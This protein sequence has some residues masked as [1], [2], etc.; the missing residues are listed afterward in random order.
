[1]LDIREIRKNPD[2]TIS[3]LTRRYPNAKEEI[4]DILAL[5]AKYLLALKAVE[6]ARTNRNKAAKE[7]GQ[8]RKQ[9][10]DTS[11]LIAEQAQANIALVAEEENLTTL[12]EKLNNKLLCIPN[13]PQKSVP[14]GISSDQ[15]KIVK[16]VGIPGARTPPHWDIGKTLE[17]F[18]IQRGT[19]L[20][21][22]GF[23]VFTGQGARLERALI[24]FFLDTNILNGYT[25]VSVPHIVKAEC[26]TG[27]GQLPKFQEDMYRTS[28]NEYLIPTAEVPITN[29]HRHEIIPKLPLKY[30]GHTPCFRREAG[31][32][33]KDT[34]GLLRVH[35]F[36]KVELVQFVE[37]SF[38]T[39]AHYEMLG[40]IEVL[41]DKLEL[42][43]R[44]VE[45]C[46]GDLGFGG[47]KCFDLEV[48]APGV[49]AWLEVSSCTN[50]LDFQARRSNIKFKS[51]GTNLLCHTL[52]GSGLALPRI[53]AA[54]IETHLQP[55]GA[56]LLPSALR[57]FFG[58]D[59]IK[60]KR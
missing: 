29:L 1:M 19:K 56:V 32:A 35:Q 24:Q 30:V 6:T 53:F 46:A 14:D 49:Q 40:H 3:D 54:L 28:E 57:P 20:S 17:L 59:S 11:A 33:G 21:G 43:Y 38:S 37:P 4:L 5:D 25:E 7:I 60:L 41:L 58:N 52:N 45:L 2:S 51:E 50:F 8:K 16:V 15:N 23:I 10:E 12:A 18:D 48:W 27:T 39:Q 55:D 26:M 47:A 22:S 36:D 13:V 44:V 31:S 34:R 9:N 42:T